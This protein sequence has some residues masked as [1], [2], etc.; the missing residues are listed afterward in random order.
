MLVGVAEDPPPPTLK[1]NSGYA[2]SVLSKFSLGNFK[3]FERLELALGQITVL[4]GPNGSGKSSVVE[5][6]MLLRQSV[7]QGKLVLTG[8]YLNLPELSPLPIARSSRHILRFELQGH[9]LVRDRGLPEQ[10]V[11]FTYELECS[12]LNGTVQANAATYSWADGRLSS[13]WPGDQARRE[14][15]WPGLQGAVGIV[16][17]N[18][19]GTPFGIASTRGDATGRVN[20][21][22]LVLTALGAE[23]NS[24]RFVPPL[25]G[26]SQPDYALQRNRL[27]ELRSDSTHSEQSAAVA[28]TLGMEEQTERQVSEWVQEVTGVAIKHALGENQR[29]GLSSLS[30]ETRE[31]IPLVSEGFGT[32]QLIW[33]MFQ[34][35]KTPEAG[36]IAIEEPE[37]HLHPFAIARLGELLTRVSNERRLSLIL[38]THSDDLL[39]SLLNNVAARELKAAQLSVYYLNKEAGPSTATRLGV[40]DKGMVKGGLPGFYDATIQAQR[41][42]IDALSKNA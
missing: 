22:Q 25:R 33:M 39:Y 38:T 27:Q 4:I 34:L 10:A 26:F 16:A 31:P 32:N 28:S 8:P 19:I 17:G 42:H 37:I 7:G 23:I 20:E 29:I 36:T 1:V 12:A 40:T 3:T 24:W 2:T 14:V 9:R 13:A 11:D 5:A 18:T 35:A 15:D 6:M 21:L 41:R 30:R